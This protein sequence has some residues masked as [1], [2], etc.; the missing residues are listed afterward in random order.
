M[1]YMDVFRADVSRC[2]PSAESWGGGSVG[3]NLSSEL[4]LS[5]RPLHDITIANIVW[6]M[7]ARTLV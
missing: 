3:V 4:P 7:L 1:L 5:S 2:G 6:Y